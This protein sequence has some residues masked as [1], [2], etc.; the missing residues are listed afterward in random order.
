[1]ILEFKWDNVRLSISKEGLVSYQVADQKTSFKAKD[2]REFTYYF[3]DGSRTSLKVEDLGDLGNIKD[4]EASLKQP[5]SPKL[6]LLI[7]KG[8]DLLERNNNHTERRRHESYSDKNDKWAALAHTGDQIL[9]H[10]I[11]EADRERLVSA[12]ARLLPQQRDLL[13][14]VYIKDIPIKEIASLEG[15]S[16][17]AI[18]HRLKKIHKRL[19]KLLKTFD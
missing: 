1:M 13:D 11:K 3:N 16:S 4:L 12:I 5:V 6:W 9:D 8:E 15:V 18:S 14:K 7:L 2:L 17:S 10:M 19:E